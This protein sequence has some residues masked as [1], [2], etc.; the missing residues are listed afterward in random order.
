L[1]KIR[2]H[3][4]FAFRDGPWGGS[5]QFLTAL[6]DGFISTG[7]WANSPD[8]ADVIL[9]DSFNQA[10]EALFWKRRLPQTSFV[11]R[12]DGPVSGYRGRDKYLDYLIYRLSARVAEGVVFQS[13]F[14]RQANLAMGMPKPRYSTVIHNAPQAFFMRRTSRQNEDLIRIVT[15]SWSANWNKGFDILDFLDRHMNFSRY[16]LTFIGNSPLRFRNIRHLPPQSPF[17]LA[18]ILPDYDIY[19]AASRHDPCSNALCEALAVGLPA[20]ALRSGGHPELVGQGGV[21]FEGTSDVIRRIDEIAADL[22]G[23][24]DRIN[25]RAISKVTKE[26]L[27]FLTQVH[28]ADAPRK[29]LTFLDMLTLHIYLLHRQMMLALDLMKRVRNNYAKDK[30]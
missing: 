14:S 5:N 7:N 23:Y 1:R 18:Q 10:R 22:A 3:I 30:K 24:R 16:S 2:V 21:L 17:A 11:H 19:L 9:F 12:I 13:E 26:Y 4:L 15:T 20:V 8:S 27:T 25:A 6:R 28:E 29:R